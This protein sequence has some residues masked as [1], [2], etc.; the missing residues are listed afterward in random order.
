MKLIWR[1]LWKIQSGHD[2]VHKRTDG[3]TR[4]RWNQYTPST[5]LSGGVY[6]WL[7]TWCIYASL[8]LNEL[9]ELGCIIGYLL[10]H[11]LQG[12]FTGTRSN[13]LTIALLAARL[14]LKDMDEIGCYQTTQR[15]NLCIFLTLYGGAHSHS[16]WG[17]NIK[18]S[19]Q[20]EPYYVREFNP[21]SST[22]TARLW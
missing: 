10:T 11:N 1:V 14:T 18:P 2:S 4:T 6:W 5:L 19:S 9:M 8:C 3:E 15:M 22:A 12:Y 17:W 20:L 13:L 16:T 7:V 21:N